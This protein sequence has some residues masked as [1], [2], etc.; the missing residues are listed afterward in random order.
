[1]TE[2]KLIAHV[3]TERVT[4]EQIAKVATPE[5]TATF[6]AVPH[7]ELIESLEKELKARG[8]EI[9]REQYAMRGD[10]SRIFGTLDLNLNGVT[11]SQ[12]SMGLRTANDKTMA[13][14]I[15][16]GLRVFVCDNLAL[17]GDF[18][19]L[20][21]KHTSGLNLQDELTGAVD[22][23]LD[24][25][26]RLKQ[27]V[28]TLKSTEL[29]DDQAKVRIYDVFDTRKLPLRLLPAVAHEYFEP[30]HDEFKPRTAWS[31]HNAFTEAVKVMPLTT[32][33][34]ATSTI[35]RQFGLN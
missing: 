11:G 8:I 15:V 9:T 24:H 27:E 17:L 28:S 2:S 5:S 31:L 20:S 30:V 22:K 23:Y 13:L 32:R 35:G 16:A 18:I 14:K 21:R 25:Y 33:L 1:M 3:D 34:A 7:I 12:A 10:G 4:R 19:A 26:G 6:K 29:T